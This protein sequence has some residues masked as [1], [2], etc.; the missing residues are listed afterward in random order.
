MSRR[1]RSSVNGRSGDGLISDRNCCPVEVRNNSPL[2][3]R[4]RL[5]LVVTDGLLAAVLFVL[6][7]AL[8]YFPNVELVSLFVILYTLVFGKRILTILLVF[9]ML[10]GLLYG[11]GVWWLSYLYVWPILAGLAWVL[12][13][14]HAP[15]WS[16]AV[17]ACLF[18]LG[19][20]A[21]CSLPYL[22]GGPGAAFAWWVAGIPYDIIHG[23]SNFVLVLLLFQP[24]RKIL[25]RCDQGRGC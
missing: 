15:D 12:K 8:M 10:E 13:Q 5:E 7:V 9:A 4:K 25:S 17:L 11:F 16:Y 19:F 22:A 3:R 23:I 20:G 24:F 14:F 6:Q 2:N 1:N 21:L 18:G